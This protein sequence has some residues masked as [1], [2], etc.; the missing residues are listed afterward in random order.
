[1]FYTLAVDEVKYETNALYWAAV[2]RVKEKGIRIQSITCDGRKGL[3]QM[4]AGI[5]VQLCHF[6]QV[7]TVNRYLTRKPKTA[8]AQDLHEVVLTLKSSS[9]FQF[10]NTL[11]GWFEKHKDFLNERT[12]HT[13]T[14]KSHY[15][16]KRLRSAYNSLKRNMD[17]LFTFERF[18]ELHIPKT[19]N[20]LEGRFGDMKQKLCCHQ[21]MRKDNKIRFIKDYFSKKQ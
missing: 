21:G 10:E 1:M 5:P 6:H 20:L 11:N 2:C 16:H 3:M 9:R 7:K 19:S 14:G 18:P 17:Y 13:E 4:F 12:V 15:T 8:A